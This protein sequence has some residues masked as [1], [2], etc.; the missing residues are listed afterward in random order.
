MNHNE[1]DE[2]K[3]GDKVNC[4]RRLPSTENREQPGKTDRRTAADVRRRAGPAAINLPELRGAIG[5]R[6]AASHGAA[7]AGARDLR[8]WREVPRV[9]GR[10]PKPRVRPGVRA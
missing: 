9:G 7:G 2:G 10:V 5:Q 3:T 1:P 4:P 6:G 8:V